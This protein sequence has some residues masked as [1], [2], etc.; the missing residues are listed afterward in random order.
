MSAA[1]HALAVGLPI[2][3]LVCTVAYFQKRAWHRPPRN[4]GAARFRD[5]WTPNV[6]LPQFGVYIAGRYVYGAGHILGPLDGAKATIEP[7]RSD[8]VKLKPT[9]GWATITFADGT[10]HRHAYAL[11]RQ[12]EAQ[13][14]LARF[15]AMAKA[16]PAGQFKR[17][18]PAH[19]A[20]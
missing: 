3:L 2:A 20:P 9:L 13:A 15:E 11:I 4:E 19:L 7:W 5:F 1:A 16:V 10:R 14:D 18:R 8:V 12:A 6:A 17:T